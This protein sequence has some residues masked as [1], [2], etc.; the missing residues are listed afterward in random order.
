M[1]SRSGPGEVDEG[2]DG[3]GVGEG[4]GGG[5][6]YVEALGALDDFAFDGWFEDADVGAFVAGSGDDAG[7]VLADLGGE[8]YSGDPFLHGT[9][10]LAGCGV[11]VVEVGGDGGEFV[12]GVRGG[13]AGE[14]GFED[15]LGDEIG[16]TAVGGGGVG[17]IEG[18]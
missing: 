1:H 12:V 2:V 11:A 17:V 9:L 3:V 8:G 4:D 14:H 16:E 15:A 13:L 10:D 6:A 18:G 5:V 7:E